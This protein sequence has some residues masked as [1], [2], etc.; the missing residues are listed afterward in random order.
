[1]EI[2]IKTDALTTRQ[3]Q[4]IQVYKLFE[5]YLFERNYHLK[6]YAKNMPQKIF[7]MCK[8]EEFSLIFKHH[9]AVYLKSYISTP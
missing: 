9:H 3:V 5:K 8:Y 4:I 7:Q 6:K 1:M 2:L